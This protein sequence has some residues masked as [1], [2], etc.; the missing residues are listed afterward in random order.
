LLVW[1]GLGWFALH[2]VISSRAVAWWGGHSFGPRILS[3][4]SVALVLL[5]ILLWHHA[6]DRLS[7][8]QKKLTVAVFLLLGAGGIYIN[9]YQGL[10]NRHTGRWNVY[11]EPTATPPFKGL[12]DM[13]NW[14]YAQFLASS[15]R[16][17]LIQSE[18]METIIAWDMTLLPYEWG[19]PIAYDG[20]THANFRDAA[21]KN[22]TRLMSPEVNETRADDHETKV[23]ELAT[24][25]PVVLVPDTRQNQGLF[26]GWS[27][28]EENANFRWSECETA[29]IILQVN[30]IDTTEDYLLI[31]KAGAFGQQRITVLVNG[32]PVGEW[33]FVEPKSSPETAVFQ[34]GGTLL[35]PN[36][37]NE[38]TFEIPNAAYA[39]KADQRRLG[40]AY[41]EMRIY[42]IAGYPPKPE[43]AAP[44]E[45]AYP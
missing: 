23:G 32:Q 13:F 25:L 15:Q 10:Y 29:R 11:T 36:A 21:R 19:T 8:S 44:A 41:Y 37:Q 31:L 45:S 18:R 4:V 6:Q 24:F 14:R 22:Y 7:L 43:P 38:V 39:G 20:D 34:F 5:I 27:V 26:I 3:D 12:G 40:L 42:P 17:C 30:D 33:T 2:V 35:Q 1:F 28:V 16:L 9:S